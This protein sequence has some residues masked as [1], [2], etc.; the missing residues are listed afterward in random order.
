MDGSPFS[1]AP[2]QKRRLSRNSKQTS[3]TADSYCV[4]SLFLTDLHP[5]SFTL[6]EPSFPEQTIHLGVQWMVPCDP[7]DY[8]KDAIYF[9]FNNFLP[10]I[11]PLWLLSSL[12]LSQ[13]L[14]CFGQLSIWWRGPPLNP[15]FILCI[16]IS[17]WPCG[18]T[19]V[20]NGHAY[21]YIYVTLQKDLSLDQS[22][23]K[24]TL[25]NLG[26]WLGLQT[27]AKDILVATEILPLTD[28]VLSAFHK[29]SSNL[30]LAIFFVG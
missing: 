28:I 21:N 27:L 26:H 2:K 15:N 7:P 6:E 25:K 9:V 5:V 17:Q 19:S 24:F 12:S 13:V 3:S 4:S 14:T 20:W 16:L 1:N 10:A 18:V 8:Q 30:L 29:D 23:D 11:Y 22:C